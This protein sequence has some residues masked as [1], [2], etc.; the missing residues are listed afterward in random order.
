MEGEK[1]LYILIAYGEKPLAGYSPY[2]GDFIMECE[3]Q[4]KQCK[5]NSSAAFVFENYKICYQN[6]D[7]ITYMVMTSKTYPN[8]ATVV[9]LDSM[10]KDYREKFISRNLSQLKNHQLDNEFKE[11]LQKKL[12]Y[13]TNNPDI[14]D[15]KVQDLK[16]VMM[17]YKE[18]VFK[19]QDELIQRGELLNK[20]EDN[21]ENL[22]NSS[23]SFKQG[24]INVRKTECRRKMWYIIVLAV[25]I[26]IIVGII[27]WIVS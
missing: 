20:L 6:V 10:I 24:A 12:E 21:S 4:L 17:Q 14:V 15:Q 19:A 18:E 7:N 22:V 26:I 27:I 3:Q 2:K 1:I 13:Y 11:S 8:P 16:E 9:C 23:F 25:A 5:P